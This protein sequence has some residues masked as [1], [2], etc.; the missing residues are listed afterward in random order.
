VVVLVVNEERFEIG[1]RP[2]LRGRYFRGLIWRD[3]ILS[4]LN[5]I[6]VNSS[7]IGRHNGGVIDD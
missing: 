1:Q 6:C 7:A 4:L 3:I 2:G 5:K